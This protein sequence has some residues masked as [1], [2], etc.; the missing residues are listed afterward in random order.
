[1]PY[2][3]SNSA[4]RNG[5]ATVFFTT[6]TLRVIETPTFLAALMARC[7]RMSIST[8]AIKLEGMPPVVVSGLPNI[9]PDLHAD[10]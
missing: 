8:E 9:T 2:M 7:R 5:G 6:L 10:L 3:I 1:V 4:S